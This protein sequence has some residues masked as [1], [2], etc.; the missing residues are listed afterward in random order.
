MVP[1][2]EGKE[3]RSKWVRKNLMYYSTIP[4]LSCLECSQEILLDLF[5]TLLIILSFILLLI[6]NI[7][8]IT[9]R[10]GPPEASPPWSSLFWVWLPWVPPNLSSHTAE[11]YLLLPCLFHLSLWTICQ[12]HSNNNLSFWTQWQTS[13]ICPCSNWCPSP[14]N[15]QDN[16]SPLSMVFSCML[17]TNDLLLALNAMN[18]LVILALQIV[19]L[20]P[21]SLRWP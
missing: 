1:S 17:F 9:W 4:L 19:L 21:F 20:V 16:S 11:V 15:M 13:G 10:F 5:F 8:N 3:I 2:Q 14:L 6:L 7:L 18:E 12:S